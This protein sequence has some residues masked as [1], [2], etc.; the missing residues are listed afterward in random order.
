MSA[1]PIPCRCRIGITARGPS[2][3]QPSFRSSIVTG[4]NAT[5]P[6]ISPLSVA[7]S[8][9]VRLA[10]FRNISTILASLPLL[11]SASRN[12][13]VISFAIVSSS[14]RVSNLI[15]IRYESQLA[16]TSAM[17]GKRTLVMLFLD[18]ALARNG[19]SSSAF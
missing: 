15:S 2:P 13:A 17:G 12:A 7:T 5:W 6:T 4:E 10:A 3:N 18:A 19:Q 11:C 8:D 16:R 9:A 14:D 1:H